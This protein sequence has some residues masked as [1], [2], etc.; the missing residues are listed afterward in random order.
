MSATVGGDVSPVR[1]WW[2]SMRFIM[3][4]DSSSPMMINKAIVIL[5]NK[6]AEITLTAGRSSP[7]HRTALTWMGVVRSVCN[8]TY[9]ICRRNWRE[10][11]YAEPVRT[12]ELPMSVGRHTDLKQAITDRKGNLSVQGWYLNHCIHIEYTKVAHREDLFSLYNVPNA[13]VA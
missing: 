6:L 10:T 3:A 9:R 12:D 8:T 13:I 7:L 5:I 11:C 2:S 4:P 1:R